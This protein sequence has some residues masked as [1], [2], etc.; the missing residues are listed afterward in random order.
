MIPRTGA[1]G[2]LDHRV[3]IIAAAPATGGGFYEQID[4]G[5][6]EVDDVYIGS[7]WM[8]ETYSFLDPEA[9]WA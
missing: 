3:R 2:L 8:L 4:Y 7:K 6:R 9:R 5:G 1:A